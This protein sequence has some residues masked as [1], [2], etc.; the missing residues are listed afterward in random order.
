M[1][2]FDSKLSCLFENIKYQ[3]NYTKEASV[4]VYDHLKVNFFQKNRIL[5]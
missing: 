2:K 4:F 3:I 1:I 5:M